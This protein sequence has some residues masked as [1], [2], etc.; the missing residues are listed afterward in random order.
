MKQEIENNNVP[1]KEECPWCGVMAYFID[2]GD[3]WE[4]C[5]NCGGN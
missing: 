3:G 4:C 2:E 5:S 1:E